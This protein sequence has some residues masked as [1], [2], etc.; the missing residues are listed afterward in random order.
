MKQTIVAINS[1]KDT[2]NTENNTSFIECAKRY[3]EIITIDEF[4]RRYNEDELDFSDT[5]IRFIEAE[6][7][8]IGCK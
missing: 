6:L 1:T 3:G 8:V 5:I 4:Q 7:E 2:S